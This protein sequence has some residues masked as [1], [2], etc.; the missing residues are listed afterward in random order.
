MTHLAATKLAATGPAHAFVPRNA[1]KLAAYERGFSLGSL[2]KTA[3]AGIL[4]ARDAL[5]IDHDRDALWARMNDIVATDVDTLRRRYSVGDDSRS[6]SL[7]NAKADV[8][9]NLDGKRICRVVHRPLDLRWT[10]YTGTTKGLHFFP[11]D[12]VSDSLFAGDT[13]ALLT[14][15]QTKEQSGAFVIDTIATHKSYSAYDITSVMPLYVTARPEKAG[16][17]RIAELGRA[18]NFD[19]EIYAAICNA[20]GLKPSPD[21]G[22]GDGFRTATGGARPSEVQVFDYIYAVLHSPAYRETYAQFL[23]I[24]FP[25]IPYPLDPATFAI[26]SQKG[27]ALRRLHLM[28]PAAIGETPYPYCGE[29]DDTVTSGYPKFDKGRVSIN[30]EQYFDVVPAVAWNLHIGGYQPAQKWLKDRR[31]RILSWDDISHYQRLVKILAE[32]DKIMREITH[33]LE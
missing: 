22:T 11:A 32:T 17:K 23:K 2:F 16:Q 29:G 14:P 9:E 26:F 30:A 8:T 15:K 13:L 28:E 10:F 20:A 18:L 12:K 19:A 1:S 5:S 31:G 6:W 7:Q 33:P 27:E 4:T 21:A 3:S 25:R 24:D